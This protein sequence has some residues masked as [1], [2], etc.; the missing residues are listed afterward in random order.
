MLAVDPQDGRRIAG[1]KITLLIEDAVVWQMC[2]AIDP[3]YLPLSQDRGRVITA[4]L[5]RLSETDYQRDIAAGLGQL[6]DCAEVVL[7]EVL[8]QQEVLRRIA[9]DGQLCEDHHLCP[10]LVSLGVEFRY[11][12]G[13]AGQIAHGRIG[14]S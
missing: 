10:G 14:L 4:L 11:P 9:A 8:F 6:L 13:V 5:C 1:L 12:L 2:L 7:E 3:G